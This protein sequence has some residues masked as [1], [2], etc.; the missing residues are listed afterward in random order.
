M[1]QGM[2]QD[3]W[4]EVIKSNISD[5][6]ERYPHT[7]KG[8]FDFK[9]PS[10]EIEPGRCKACGDLASSDYDITNSM[11]GSQ[12]A[13]RPTAMVKMAAIGMDKFELDDR[14]LTVLVLP[15]AK[16]CQRIYQN[17]EKL[18]DEMQKY[19][20][21]YDKELS[22]V[23]VRLL[24]GATTA[25]HESG[26][27]RRIEAG[28]KDFVESPRGATKRATIS[29]I[30]KQDSFP[31]TPEDHVALASLAYLLLALTVGGYAHEAVAVT[32]LISNFIL[33]EASRGEE[34]SFRKV[35]IATEAGKLAAEIHYKHKLYRDGQM[36]DSRG[37]FASTG[38]ILLNLIAFGDFT[39]TPPQPLTELQTF[40]DCVA[41]AYH[42]L[43][44]L[45][46]GDSQEME[47]FPS[48]GQMETILHM[49][50]LATICEAAT[51]SALRGVEGLIYNG[52]LI[53]HIKET[54]LN[55][56][57]L[58]FTSRALGPIGDF[59]ALRMHTGCWS[60]AED[61]CI[62]QLLEA[63]QQ[64]NEESWSLVNLALERQAL[65]LR[66]P[67]TGLIRP[68]ARKACETVIILHERVWLRQPVR[69]LT[70]CIENGW[71][72]LFRKNLTGEALRNGGQAPIERSTEHIY[73]ESNGYTVLHEATRAGFPYIM[74][75]LLEGLGIP[76]CK[77]LV[78]QPDPKGRTPL[79]LACMHRVPKE[80]FRLLLVLGADANARCHQGRTALHYCFPDQMA[81]PSIY[82]AV[83]TMTSDHA[84][85]TIEPYDQPQIYT[86]G[87][88][89]PVDPRVYDFRLGISQVLGLRGD[90]S[91]TDA[92]GMTPL[93][94]AAKLG[95][96]DN[97]DIFF[98]SKDG[99]AER[100]QRASLTLRDNAGLTILDYTRRSEV[101]V[102]MNR[103]E[104]TIIEEMSRRAIA[105]PLKSAHDRWHL[106]PQWNL[107]Q[108]RRS[109]SP[110][111]DAAVHAA[112]RATP[113]PQP[114]ARFTAPLVYQ[115]PEFASSNRP[116]A[117]SCSTPTTN[118]PK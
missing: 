48:I 89:K 13:Q 74:K 82:E 12:S 79:H 92:D 14:S 100:L 67:S 45:R 18:A 59:L 16:A 85:P 107:I 30:L 42:L 63:C 75:A 17:N 81:V 51:T 70:L 60:P 117:P 37:G 64:P 83:T 58:D 101:H 116:S 55:T 94:M 4:S 27:K 36:S 80:I 39:S 93:H 98:W 90:M 86:K 106:Q 112:P 57:L 56:P 46:R 68:A 25:F 113:S 15:S 44:A 110:I 3:A 102:G 47:D 2:V 50:T 6:L 7:E 105:V 40:F 54:L 43:T 22:L 71:F 8:E 23:Y 115:D 103:G 29:N 87:A 5:G 65:E 1:R 52:S 118:P 41:G 31:A 49:A 77:K 95:W 104:D 28:V 111:P 24:T 32:D 34:G 96:G 72:E 73:L 38:T 88:C 84:L 20:V 10:A 114:G 69:L 53:R 99:N 108:Y 19:V 26:I 76:Y 109:K 97:L 33:Y 62:A 61:G 35:A 9:R 21:P 78:N 91:I 11:P 66:L